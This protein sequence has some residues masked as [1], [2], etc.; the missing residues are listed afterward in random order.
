[1]RSHNHL[2]SAAQRGPLL[3]AESVRLHEACRALRQRALFV[4]RRTAHL[5]QRSSDLL[6][7]SWFQLRSGGASELRLSARSAGCARPQ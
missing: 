2:S 3:R 5:C 1:M 6:T 4:S 7:I